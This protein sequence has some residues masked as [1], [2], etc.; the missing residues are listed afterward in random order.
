MGFSRQEYWSGVPCPSPGQLPDP[1][2]E[3]RSLTLQAD[4]LPS[5]P[6]GNLPTPRQLLIYFPSVLIFLFW[7]LTMV[8]VV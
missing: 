5:E 4:S 2:I 1:G 7:T 3:P 8:V 6:L